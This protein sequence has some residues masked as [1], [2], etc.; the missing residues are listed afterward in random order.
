MLRILVEELHSKPVSEQKVEFVERKGQGHPDHLIDSC[1]EAVSLALSRH[2]LKNFGRIL[3]H[4]VDK[5]L[6][7]GGSSEPRFG[8]GT[9][10]E[11]MSIVV[12]GRATT[13]FKKDGSVQEVP[14]DEIARRASERKLRS[15][16]R[17]IEPEKHVR[18]DFRIRPGSADLI[19]LFDRTSSLPL[20]NDTSF[21][22]AF[23]PF[24]PVE[25]LTLGI[26]RLLNSSEFKKKYPAVGEDIKVMSLRINSDISVTISAPLIDR[27]VQSL[28][29]YVGVLEEAHDRVL[30]F[31]SEQETYENVEVT[32]NR[33]DDLEKGEIYLS[34]IGTSA[35]GG[36]DGNTGRSNRIT[37]LITPNRQMSLEATA[38][39][40]PVN[41]V[42]KLYNVLAHEISRRVAEEVE[43]VAEAYVRILSRIGQ[44]I[45]RPQI[46]NVQV[47]PEDGRFEALTRD[48]KEIVDY[49]VSNV[50]RLT[51][52]ILD[53][54]VVL[55]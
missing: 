5:G 37:G 42:G 43:G 38:G 24:S 27:F 6:L 49:E 23:A 12:A 14:V 52:L 47:I 45:N 44:P 10:T 51:D 55:F 1:C 8:G 7:I 41:H 18:M 29:D 34:V 16:L 53:E 46:V 21:G 4:N 48:V 9:V 31:V 28:G 20:S 22:V 36:D 30:D 32:M 19:A 26:E 13:H 15:L 50:R 17:F 33:A 25:R 54:K 11:P 2:Y 3:H 35:E 39:K 40:N